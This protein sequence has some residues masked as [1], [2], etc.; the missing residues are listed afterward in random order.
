MEQLTFQL[1]WL[2]TGGD[3]AFVY[4]G[5]EEGFYAEEG[6][7]IKVL[8]GRGTTDALTKIGSGAADVGSGG[9]GALMMAQAE[10]GIPVKAVMSIYTKQPDAIF[11]YEGSG[12]T[13]F[14]SLQGKT[15]GV[16][17]FSTSN[18]LLPLML[19]VNGVDPASVKQVKADP[20]ALVP[21]MAQGRFDGVV[22]WTTNT[23]HVTEL[24][25]KAG[26]KA[27]ILPWSDFGLD[28]Y[29]WSLFASQK[30]IA[31]KPQVV[32]RFVRASKKAV[33]FTLRHPDKAA[34]D[35]KALVP[36]ADSA[37]LEAD[38]RAAQGLIDN[39]ISQRDGLGHFEPGLLNKTWA[40]VAKSMNYPM[41]RV[42]PQSLVDSRFI[43]Q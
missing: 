3:K 42:D 38:S 36:E 1:D 16:P 5:I 12:V 17:T 10:G 41:D 4:A 26:K 11:T 6:L 2:P 33:E 22:I 31:E 39:E 14:K 29:G 23:P 15:L 27:V 43:N 13:D 19:S 8:A 24:L 25:K 37:M 18:T 20:S 30:L 40:W 21:M 32:A 28:G 35:Q 34:A 7:E 9:I